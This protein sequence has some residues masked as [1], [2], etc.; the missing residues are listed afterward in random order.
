MC[1]ET[2]LTTCPFM[3]A[4]WMGQK[5]LRLPRLMPPTPHLLMVASSLFSAT[6]SSHLFITRHAQNY[7]H[8]ELTVWMTGRYNSR[9]NQ[10]KGNTRISIT[11][12]PK[13]VTS[14]THNTPE[15]TL[16]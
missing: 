15:L 9:T 5:E 10:L 14:S 7:L 12:V 6:S 8:P 4:R 1:Y 11:F 3:T 13:T 16:A 2:E